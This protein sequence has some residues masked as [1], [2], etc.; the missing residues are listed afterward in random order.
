MLK[1]DVYTEVTERNRRHRM[2]NYL[3]IL[4]RSYKSKNENVL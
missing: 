1:A 4:T 3:I 2:K